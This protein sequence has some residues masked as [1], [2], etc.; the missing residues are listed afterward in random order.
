MEQEKSVSLGAV[1]CAYNAC[2]F[3]TESV[4]R[5]YPVVDKIIFL[6][7]FKPWLG[8]PFPAI[9]RTI[10][11]ILAI[12][13]DKS[14]FEIVIGYWK[15]EAEQRNVGLKILREKDISWCLIIDDDELYNQGELEN[16]RHMLVSAMHAAYLIYH[17]I[18]W[19]NRDTIIEGLFGSFPTFARTDGRVHFNE[20]RM[21]LVNKEYTWFSVSADAIVCHH[22]SYIRSDEE[23]SRKIQSFSHAD[24][25]VSDWYERIWLGDVTTDLHP[26]VGPRFKRTLPAAESDYQLQPFKVV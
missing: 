20:N 23:M 22:M 5:I 19:K 13:D 26:S 1:Y 6:V 15:N 2:S 24:D 7:N 11:D 8:E 12:P 9:E 4:Q 10:S 3:L 16:I 21:I 25:V 17:Q 14:K 18:Y